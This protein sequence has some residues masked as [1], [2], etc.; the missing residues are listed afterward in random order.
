VLYGIS[1]AFLSESVA[2]FRAVEAVNVVDL[3]IRI[4]NFSK[5]SNF[6]RFFFFF[7]KTLKISFGF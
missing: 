4:P 5:K 7:F 1:D 2:A 6:W 3:E